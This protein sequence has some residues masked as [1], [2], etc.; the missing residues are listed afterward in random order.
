MFIIIINLYGI[1]SELLLRRIFQAQSNF[2][3]EALLTDHA[4]NHLLIDAE[5]WRE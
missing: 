4:L 5:V 3:C 2:L 1:K